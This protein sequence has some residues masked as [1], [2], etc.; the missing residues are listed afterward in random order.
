MARIKSKTIAKA[1]QSIARTT[2]HR[3]IKIDS[4]VSK[5]ICRV[6][7]AKDLPKLIEKMRLSK[8]RAYR[9]K[10]SILELENAPISEIKGK[11]TKLDLGT[12]KDV[13]SL[14]VGKD[15]SMLIGFDENNSQIYLYDVIDKRHM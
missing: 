7:A 1:H 2:K 6:Q 10:Q 8:P 12:E 14:R 11:V 5:S 13:Y 15:M 4:P 9:L 3:T